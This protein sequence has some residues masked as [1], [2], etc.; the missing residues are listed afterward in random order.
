[1]MS[2]CE[3]RWTELARLQIDAQLTA[4]ERM[5][6]DTNLDILRQFY[7]RMFASNEHDHQDVIEFVK[8]LENEIIHH[9]GVGRALFYDFQ[10]IKDRPKKGQSIREDLK[11]IYPF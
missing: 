11:C 7:D 3:E 1:L 8:T 10:W 9:K 5:E 2:D 6:P 4:F